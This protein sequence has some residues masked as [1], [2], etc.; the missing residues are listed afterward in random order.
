MN[1]PTF[2]SITWANYQFVELDIR[3]KFETHNLT[4]LTKFK[5]PTLVLW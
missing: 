3:F 4:H 2:E 1:F 5:N